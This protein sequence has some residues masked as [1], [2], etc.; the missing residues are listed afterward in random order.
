[1]NAALSP[2]RPSLVSSSPS[3]KPAA[4][5]FGLGLVG[6]MLIGAVTNAVNGRVAPLYFQVV[7]G[8]DGDVPSAAIGQG[9]MEGAV[10][11]LILG[12]IVAA[13][14]TLR[15]RGHGSTLSALRLVGTLLL[16]ALGAWAVGGVFGL[17]MGA[18]SPG[19]FQQRFGLEPDAAVWP[20]AWVG[21]SITGAELGAIIT[22]LLGCVVF[23]VRTKPV[24]SCPG[25]RP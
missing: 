17:L 11:G 21:G 18:V 3:W 5:A 14:F 25:A 24:E 1:M 2:L 7:L 12:G 4:A 19:W 9:L 13:L 22:T 8:W 10:I 20:V 16:L 6:S 15:T 23:W